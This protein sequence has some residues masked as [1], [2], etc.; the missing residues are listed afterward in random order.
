MFE[1]RNFSDHKIEYTRNHSRNWETLI[2]EWVRVIWKSHEKK[3]KMRN[4]FIALIHGR[5]IKNKV[6]GRG[7]LKWIYYLSSTKNNNIF[8]L[9]Y[10]SLPLWVTG[11]SKILRRS[12]PYIVM[13]EEG[14][15]KAWWWLHNTY[16]SEW[17]VHVQEAAIVPVRGV[18]GNRS[19]FMNM[20][21]S[22]LS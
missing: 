6:K 9:T 22:T 8:M 1:T 5:K 4:I 19:S 20:V 13:M 7:L 3:Q 10:Y 2:M 12:L 18:K 15:C 11:V 21:N 17:T 14:S 16:K